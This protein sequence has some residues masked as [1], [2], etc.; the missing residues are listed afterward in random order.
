MAFSYDVEIGPGNSGSVSDR[1][2]RKAGDVS[3]GLQYGLYR[4][5]GRSLPWDTGPNKVSVTYLL[6]LFGSWQRNTIYGRI[7]VG[8]VVAS[9]AYSDSPAVVVTY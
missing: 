1:R 7:P 5:G 3:G 4:D 9:G 6:A 8:Q 2:M